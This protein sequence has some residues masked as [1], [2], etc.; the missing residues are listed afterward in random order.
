MRIADVESGKAVL[1]SSRTKR[2][3]LNFVLSL[4]RLPYIL[5]LNPLPKK[6]SKYMVSEGKQA[7]CPTSLK[8]HKG[9]TTTG[10]NQQISPERILP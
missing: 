1:T 6:S 8:I 2:F 7:L 3:N 5:P 10:V 4:V 9:V